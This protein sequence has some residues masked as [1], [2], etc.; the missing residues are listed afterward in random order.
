MR[1]FG[2]RQN[3]GMGKRIAIFLPNL[4]GGG[5]ERVALILAERLIAEGHDVDLVLAKAEGVLLG[6]VPSEARVIDLNARRL[7]HAL[8]GYWRYLRRE[9][10]D[11]VQASL[12]PLTAVTIAAARMARSKAR[13]VVSDHNRLSVQYGG[14]RTSL[15]ALRILMRLLYPLA[16]VRVCVSDGVAEDLARLSG[17]AKDRFTVIHNPV[18][19]PP[20]APM[21]PD[22]EI[23]RLWAGAGQRI[24]TVG[25]LKPQKNQ[26]LLVQGLALLDKAFDARLMILGEGPLRA[27]LAQLASEL[28]VADR[29][30]MPGFA[31]DP[32]PYYASADQF[33][34]SSDYEGFG[35]VLVEAMAAGLPVVSTDCPSGPAEILDGGKYGRLVPVGD[36][37]ALAVAIADSLANPAD[38]DKLKARARQ[39][40][41]EIAV[42]RYLAALTGA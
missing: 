23:E 36:A 20:E 28:G 34:L 29:V 5:A 1:A 26:A 38:A 11:A 9:R 17:L 18:P 3:I 33:V 15:A 32:W 7:R 8:S 40:R 19:Q 22:P 30:I 27:Q 4:T 13:I 16:A 12:W 25:S 39:F 35:N 24:L 41:P 37:R 10:P 2:G 6:I 42:E 21:Q 31:T 14:S